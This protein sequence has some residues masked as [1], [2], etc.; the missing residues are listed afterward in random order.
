M[1]A[2]ELLKQGAGEILRS[3]TGSGIHNS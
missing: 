2:Q 1:V 3:A